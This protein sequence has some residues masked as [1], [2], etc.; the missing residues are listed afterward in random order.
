VKATLATRT[1][2]QPEWGLK[3]SVTLMK[4]S[5]GTARSMAMW[6]IEPRADSSRP[7]RLIAQ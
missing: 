6:V 4:S 1:S 2:H 5:A 3:F 7:P